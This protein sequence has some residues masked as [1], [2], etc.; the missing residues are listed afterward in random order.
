MSDEWET[1][2][3]LFRQLELT[4]GPFE[5]D[6]CATDDNHL[7]KRWFTVEDDGLEMAWAG[8]V[9]MNPPYSQWAQWCAKAVREVRVGRCPRVVALLPSDTSTQAFHRLVWGYAEVT[10]LPK[11]VKFYE[12]GKEGKHPAR[13]ASLVAVWRRI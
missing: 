5:L 12:K 1:P 13:F 4:H 10:F 8:R 7:C 3:W 9:F 6:P 2:P 11:R